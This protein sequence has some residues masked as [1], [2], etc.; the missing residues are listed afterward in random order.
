MKKLTAQDVQYMVTKNVSAVVVVGGKTHMVPASDSRY[1]A[2][3]EALNTKNYSVLPDLLDAGKAIKSYM[4]GNLE[5]HNGGVYYKGYQLGGPVIDR[6]L[7]AI[8]S[9]ED[10]ANRLLA[11]INKLQD[12]TSQH[13]VQQFYSFMENKGLAIA[14]DGDVFG[15]KGVGSNYMSLRSGTEN[16]EV[17]KDG[18]KT[19]EV[20]KGYIP[21]AIGNIV[22]IPRNLVVDNPNVHCAPGLHVGSL[23]YATNWAG[24]SGKV[25]IV[26]FNPAN[27]VS[28]PN[29]HDCKKLR[30][31]EY[32]VV[33][34]CEGELPSFK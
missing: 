32:T 29:D 24:H 19:W 33:G 14:E 8:G 11:F 34:D 3:V 28:V 23:D 25:V 31:C 7:D 18:G 30:T 21:N 1:T 6:V 22:R 13:S 16:V 12:N 20:H 4:K 27:A 5:V 26:K 10:Y 2:V 15:Y 17:S 9:K